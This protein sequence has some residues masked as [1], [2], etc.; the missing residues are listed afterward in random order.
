[1]NPSAY[2]PTL[3][4]W[5]SEEEDLREGGGLERD[6]DPRSSPACAGHIDRIFP[7]DRGVNGTSREIQGERLSLGGISP[8]G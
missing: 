3:E 5:F 4:A 7:R 8:H 2:T 6:W 1:M